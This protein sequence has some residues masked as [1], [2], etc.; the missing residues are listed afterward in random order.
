MNGQRES[1]KMNGQKPNP[2]NELTKNNEEEKTSNRYKKKKK[3]IIKS[4]TVNSNKN[5]KRQRY[6]IKSELNQ[7]EMKN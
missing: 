5:I 6:V 4:R 7:T 3:K 1:S 2:L